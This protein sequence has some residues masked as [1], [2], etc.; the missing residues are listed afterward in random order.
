VFYI[1]GSLGIVWYL[2]WQAKS[3][4][5]PATCASISAEERSYI[6]ASA[7]KA[8]RFFFKLIL[9]TA[10]QQSHALDQQH[11]NLQLSA[12]RLTSVNKILSA[13]I[14]HAFNL[15]LRRMAPPQLHY[16]MG[17]RGVSALRR[18]RVAGSGAADPLGPA[19]Q[20]GTRVGADR[21]PLLPQLGHL[22]PA[23]LDA[24]LLQPG[25]TSFP[26]IFASH[27]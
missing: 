24:H 7:V 14:K 5:S 26:A 3:E 21:V 6:E 17:T 1:F 25:A 18:A 10:S 20:Q 9:H 19:A 16:A 22:H 15:L 8:V 27:S 13:D 23:D 4:S 2:V 11:Q 12:P